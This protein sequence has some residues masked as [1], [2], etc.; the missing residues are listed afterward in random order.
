MAEN[1]KSFNDLSINAIL[2]HFNEGKGE[3]YINPDDTKKVLKNPRLYK[4][5]LSDYEVGNSYETMKYYT[6]CKGVSYASGISVKLYNENSFD[7]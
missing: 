7:L 4:E 6:E 1:F 3:G 5:N 2:D